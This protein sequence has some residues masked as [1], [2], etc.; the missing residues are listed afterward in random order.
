[1]RFP[2]CALAAL[3]LVAGACGGR[4]PAAAAPLADE[5]YINAMADLLRLDQARRSRPTPAWPAPAAGRLSTDTAWKAARR[6]ESLKVV[7]ADSA[8]RAAV[9][10]R[11]GVTEAQLEATAIA[12]T[13]Q[14]RR[15]RL[16]WDSITTR[17]ARQ[18]APNESA[19]KAAAPAIT[20]PP[21][22]AVSAPR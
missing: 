4:S 14:T 8:A 3:I 19:G 1:M 20:T 17:A 7:R 5:A 18:R 9:L 2:T 21:G 6:A 13:E 12:L 10:T 15:A 11:H 16:V 22:G